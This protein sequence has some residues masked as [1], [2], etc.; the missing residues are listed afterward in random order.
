MIELIIFDCDGVLVDSEPLANRQFAKHLT[1]QGLSI[2][3]EQ[4]EE[5]FKGRSLASCCEWAERQL[6]RSLPEHF[7]AELQRDT[8]AAFRRELQPLPGVAELLASLTLPVCVA[9][10]GQHDKLSLTLGVTG[11]IGWFEGRV[12]S[13]DDVARGKPAPDLFLYA[14]QQMAVDPQQALVIEDSLPGVQAAVAAGMRCF[15]VGED[16]AGAE[17]IEAGAE[18]C[19]DIEQLRRWLSGQSQATREG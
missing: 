6:G 8:F 4:C 1:Q 9:S 15:G 3:P 10:S 2:T 14:A 5:V 12:F 16:A 17:L 18:A 19:G 7:I 11:L 13:V